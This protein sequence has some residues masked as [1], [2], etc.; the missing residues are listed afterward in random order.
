MFV[1]IE[2]KAPMIPMANSLY[3]FSP[4]FAS[5]QPSPKERELKTETSLFG[6]RLITKL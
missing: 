2:P 4:Y 1:K 5:P 6:F 3:N